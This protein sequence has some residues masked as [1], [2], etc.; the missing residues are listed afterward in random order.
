VF[1]TELSCNK[2]VMQAK[3]LKGEDSNGLSDP[4]VEVVTF[5]QK[6]TSRIHKKVTT[7]VFDEM[8]VFMLP[9]LRAQDIEQGTVKVGCCSC[10]LCR[11]P[12]EASLHA[13]ITLVVL[14][15]YCCLCVSVR[16]TCCALSC[17]CHRCLCLTPTCCAMS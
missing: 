8:F 11:F 17:C 15:S 2:V 10:C 9:K 7:C 5:G 3:D 14:C 6:R 16:G 13:I 1:V 4:V 12:V